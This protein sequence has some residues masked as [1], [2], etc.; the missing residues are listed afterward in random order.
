[1]EKKHL[2]I[3]KKK[4]DHNS[5]ELDGFLPCGCLRA[6]LRVCM[7]MKIISPFTYYKVFE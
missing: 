6:L 7:L 1:M 2:L 5:D 4:V 3:K